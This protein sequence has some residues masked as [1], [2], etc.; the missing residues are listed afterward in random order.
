LC[1]HFLDEAEFLADNMVIMAKGEIKT[2]GSVSELKSTLGNGYRVQ[3]LTPGT[4][5]G[6]VEKFEELDTV[7]D[8]AQALAIIKDLESK[9][10]KNYQ[11]AGPTIEEVFMKLAADRDAEYEDTELEPMV[12]PAKKD[13]ESVAAS[14][15]S[16]RGEEV[17]HRVGAL[18][19]V[20]VLIRKRWT[21]FQRSPLPT[22]I[23]LVTP[24]VAAGLLSILMRH[25][26]NPD[27]DIG[28]Q[29]SVSS[30]ALL[31]PKLNPLL[32]IGPADAMTPAS[33]S[34]V[35]G[36]FPNNTLGTGNGSGVLLDS[37]HLVN[38]FAEYN[39]YTQ[40]KF[41]N[42]TPGGLY[43]GD[44]TTP[45][46]ISIR[47]D[48]FSPGSIFSAVFLQNVLDVLLTRVRI[49]ASFTPYDFA[50]PAGTGESLQFIFYFGLVMCAAPAFFG[51]YPSRE[52]VRNVR[53]MEYS[54]G[55]RPLP[56][57]AAYALFDFVNVLV[58]SS[59][60]VVIFATK[61]E[62]SWY[63]IGYFYVVLLL[64]GLAAILLTYVISK[65]AGSHFAAF[66]CC[67][68]GQGYVFWSIRLLLT[69]LDSCF[70]FTS[71]PT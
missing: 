28:A 5:E 64:Y 36:I 43:L 67:A 51:L 59:F 25:Y 71:H 13:R 42:L 37:I 65:I 46:T 27:C 58:S 2:T 1:T 57:W 20:K 19:Q 55:V 17:R 21:V 22:L 31:D 50:W 32:A 9:G 40:Q 10:I 60:V 24:I 56:L 44:A 3:V 54:N 52:R 12:S 48:L 26:K 66:A 38:S 18:S 15:K 29:F 45:P 4:K 70:W 39:A 68:G 23:A 63:N 62:Q 34:L 7:A 47:S 11:I 49:A 16:L 61:N 8:S 69:V 35:A 53:A 30:T 41:A 14:L 6:E 33:L